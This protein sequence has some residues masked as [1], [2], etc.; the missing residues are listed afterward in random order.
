MLTSLSGAPRILLTQ[1][2]AAYRFGG[3]WKVPYFQCKKNNFQKKNVK[4]V[5]FKKSNG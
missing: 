2:D 4:V 3:L 5:E 1:K